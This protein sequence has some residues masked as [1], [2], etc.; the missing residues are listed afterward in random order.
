MRQVVPTIIK[1]P[2][3]DTARLRVLIP[4]RT[5]ATVCRLHMSNLL[6]QPSREAEIDGARPVNALGTTIAVRSAF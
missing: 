1:Q 3:D 6:I 4:A 2:S 5:S